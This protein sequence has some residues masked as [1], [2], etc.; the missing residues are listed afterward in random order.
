MSLKRYYGVARQKARKSRAEDKFRADF[1]S[2]RPMLMGKLPSTVSLR[3]FM[4]KVGLINFC[5]TIG[6]LAM[7]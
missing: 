1:S 2:T 3:F 7:H 6:M 5:S 4:C